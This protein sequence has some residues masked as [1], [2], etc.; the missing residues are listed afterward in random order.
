M[1]CSAD[2]LVDTMLPTLLVVSITAIG[3]LV[4][5]EVELFRDG[6]RRHA[7]INLAV[8]CVPGDPV[9][10]GSDEQRCRPLELS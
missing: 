9:L 1:C 7:T 2:A 5:F 4:R 6:A 3:F 8:I 10:V